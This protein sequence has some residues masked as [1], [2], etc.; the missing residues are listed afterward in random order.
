MHKY[1]KDY[2]KLG[3]KVDH[4]FPLLDPDSDFF[5]RV[6]SHKTWFEQATKDNAFVTNPQ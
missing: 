4:L 3:D 6:E 5:T 2:D 1:T